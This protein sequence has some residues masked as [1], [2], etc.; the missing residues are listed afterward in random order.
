MYHKF[1]RHPSAKWRGF[2]VRCL[3]Q[4][5]RKGTFFGFFQLNLYSLFGGLVSDTTAFSQWDVNEVHFFMPKTDLLDHPRS[6]VLV[7]VI[8][9]EPILNPSCAFYCV[10]HFLVGWRQGH[11]EILLWD[12]GLETKQIRGFSI[13]GADYRD[14]GCVA[15]YWVWSFLVL[16]STQLSLI[17]IWRCRR[18]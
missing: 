3:F 6:R 17:H 10:L 5:I 14:L 15:G 18:A 7:T 2:G 12:R 11:W 13:G 16:I 9:H 1:Q 8:Y 4:S